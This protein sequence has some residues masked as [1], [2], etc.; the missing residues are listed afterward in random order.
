MFLTLDVR[1]VCSS[2]SQLEKLR[3]VDYLT[4]M[5]IYFGFTVAGDRSTIDAAVKVVRLLEEQGHQ[6]LTRHLLRDDAWEADRSISPQS[7][8]I[9]GNTHSNCTLVPY[10]SVEAVEGVILDCLRLEQAQRLSRAKACT[11]KTRR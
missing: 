11:T 9:S 7:L 2:F 10:D 3:G 5:K 4:D 1:P 6:V 8:L